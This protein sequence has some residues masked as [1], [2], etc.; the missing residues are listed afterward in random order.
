M[1]AKQIPCFISCLSSCPSELLA[2]LIIC[3]RAEP[4][5]ADDVEWGQLISVGGHNLDLHW[6][7]AGDMNPWRG[8][9]SL[10]E[11]VDLQW[12]DNQGKSRNYKDNKDRLRKS[13]DTWI[14]SSYK[15]VDLRH[16]A[17]SL[18]GVQTV[19]E[20]GLR[21]NYNQSHN[22]LCFSLYFTH[23]HQRC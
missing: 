9:K 10:K 23:F 4:P 11:L 7:E 8:E 15:D 22:N 16:I 3:S 2:L 17:I 19:S 14:L 1:D 21:V 12:E 5:P 6:T 20:R 13:P 18:E